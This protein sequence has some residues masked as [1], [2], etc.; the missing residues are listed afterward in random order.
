MADVPVPPSSLRTEG[1]L[2]REIHVNLLECKVCFEKYNPRQKERR[3]QNLSC[4]HV[5]CLEC[6]RALSHPVLKKLECPFCRQLCDVDSTSHCQAL[7][8]LQDLLL[9]RSPRSPVPHRV[10]G[11]SGWVGGLGSGALRLRSA[12]GGWGSLINP[13]GVAVFGSSGTLVVVHDGERRVVVF[14]PQGRRLHGFGRRGRGHGEVCHPVDVAVTPSGY[15]VVTDAGDGAV[16]VFTSRGSYVLAV[17]DSF[18]MPW[19]VDVDSCGHILV[20]DIQA[21]TLSQVVVDFARGVTLMN[22]A[23]ITDL[24]RPKAVACC[25]VTGNIALV[26]TLGLTTTQP[27]NGPRPTRLTI[28]NKD[29]NVLSQIDSFTLSLGAS[30]WPCMSA[31]AFDRDGDV[32]VIDS[33]RGLIWSLGKLQNGPVLTPLVSGDLVRP[34]G[35][36]ATAQNTLIVLD[37]GDHAVKMYSVHSDAILVQK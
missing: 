18:Q 8:D 19:G 37:S 1:I 4:G 35:L 12:F 9:S 14:G 30:V 29:F 27:S 16:K 3:P 10:R 20:T 22:R 17:W 26:E 24:Q 7:T 25:R 15:V 28:F 36:V 6:V 13:T 34:V 23:V 21:G 32:I 31:V 33:Q 5:L 2:L 11:G